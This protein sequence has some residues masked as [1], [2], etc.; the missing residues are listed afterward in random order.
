MLQLP[1]L[2]HLVRAQVADS[3]DVQEA[4]GI[5]QSP[6]ETEPEAQAGWQ[7]V[8]GVLQ[9]HV[10]VRAVR[11]AIGYSIWLPHVQNP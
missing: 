11:Q 2:A 3:L 7:G 6:R 9:D 5:Q 10:C 8:T 1:C 4:G